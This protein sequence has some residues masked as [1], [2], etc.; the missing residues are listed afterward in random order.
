MNFKYKQLVVFIIF[1]AITSCVE[2]GKPVKKESEATKTNTKTVSHYTCPNGHKGSDNQGKCPT[3]GS[4]YLHNQA[5]HGAPALNLPQNAIQDPFQKNSN[6][7]NTPSP[8]RNAFGDFHYTCP[9]GHSGGSGTA[10]NCTTCNTK[11]A[12]N[13]LY[14]K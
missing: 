13:Q 14:H 2:R 10:T 12:H 8:A 11:L 3:C 7:T 5:Y 9:K 1:L 6:A 4:V